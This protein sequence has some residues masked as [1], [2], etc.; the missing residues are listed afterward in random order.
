MDIF[1]NS[2]DFLNVLI[3]RQEYL[4]RCSISPLL[5]SILSVTG[6]LIILLCTHAWT[7]LGMELTITIDKNITEYLIAFKIKHIRF[8]LMYYCTSGNPDPGP[9]LCINVN[10]FVLPLHRLKMIRLKFI[11]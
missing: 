3:I 1:D 10:N 9:L 8:F 7:H 5:H 4:L 2:M 6:S 11:P